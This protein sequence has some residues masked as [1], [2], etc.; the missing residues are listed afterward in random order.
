MAQLDAPPLSPPL[1]STPGVSVAISGDVWW[2]GLTAQLTLTNTSAVA[3]ETWS[4]VFDSPHQLSGT[5]WGATAERIDLGNGLWRYTLTGA[6]W[7]SRLPA[8][9]SVSV[10]FNA[11]QGR[12]I[13]SSGALAA[14]SSPREGRQRADCAALLQASHPSIDGASRKVV[15]LRHCCWMLPVAR[16]N[17]KA[18]HP[19]SRAKEDSSKVL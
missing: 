15:R 12:A 18:E 13:G 9:G 10:G 4:V 3:L 11:T 1:S 2:N 8:G 17:P 7:A 6:G 14:E 5:P 19:L 16:Q